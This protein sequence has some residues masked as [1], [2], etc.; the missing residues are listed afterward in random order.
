M[1]LRDVREA[2]IPEIRE[3]MFFLTAGYSIADTADTLESLSEL[4][5][6]LGICHLLTMVDIDKFRE[7]L[8]H[9]GHARRYFLR[10]SQGNA[11][12]LSQNP[13]CKP[14]STDLNRFC[15]VAPLPVLI[16]VMRC[17]YGMQ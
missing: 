16:Y 5:Q 12:T 14:F 4:F 7:N 9:S 17:C 1:D 11:P 15:R 8:V 6:G 3:K 13:N 2:I 10:K